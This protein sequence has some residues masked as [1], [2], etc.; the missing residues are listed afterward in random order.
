MAKQMT[1]PK[2]CDEALTRSAETFALDVQRAATNPDCH[3]WVSASAGTGKTK[4]LTDRILNLLLNGVNPRKILC[5]TF[6]NAAA[7]EMM[8]RLLDRLGHWASCSESALMRELRLL[9]RDGDTAFQEQETQKRARTLF[10]DIL[11]IPGGIRI[12]TIHSF[13]QSLLASFPLEAGLAL[14]TTILK[15]RER[16][17]ILK[18]SQEAVLKSSAHNPLL[19]E[20]MGLL[21]EQFHSET[22]KQLCDTLLEERLKLI[23]VLA[24]GLDAARKTTLEALD[25]DSIDL[26]RTVADKIGMI[27][28]ATLLDRLWNEESERLDALKKAALALLEGRSTDQKRGE[29]VF[30]WLEQPKTME[31]F[32]A[33]ASHFLTLEGEIRQKLATRDVLTSFP[34]VEDIL[35]KEAKRVQE[36]SD[37]LKRLKIA[38]ISLS[39]LTLGDALL[40]HYEALKT[41]QR[42]LDYD[43]LILKASALL[44]HSELAPW[45][46]Y[47]L[48]GGIDHLLVDEAQDTNTLQ[49]SIIKA[50]TEEFFAGEGVKA[51][52][53][54]LFAV[55]DGKQS[56]YS[57]QGTD[58]HIF[59][60]MRAYFARALPPD[61]K[62]KRWKDLE[63]SLSFRS[64]SAILDFIDALFA[65]EHVRDGVCEEDGLRHLCFRTGQAG[66]VELWPL[67]APEPTATDGHGQE[68]TQPSSA[69]PD[70]SANMAYT[71]TARTLLAQRVANQIERWLEK[72]TFLPSRGRPLK[73]DDIMVLVRNRTEFV[74]ALIQSL[75]AK[76]IPVSGLDRLDLLE[77]LAIQDLIALSEFLLLPENDFALA[78]V[79]KSPFGGLDE[80]ALFTLATTRNQKSLWENLKERRSSLQCFQDLFERLSSLLAQVDFVSPFTLYSEILFT[81]KGLQKIMARFGREAMDPIEE[82]LGLAYDYR[83][84]SSSSLQGFLHWLGQGPLKIKRDFS[85]TGSGQIRTM[86]VH[87]AKGLQAPVVILADTASRPVLRQDFLWSQEQEKKPALLWSPS[88]D[89]ETKTTRHLKRQLKILQDQ[90]YRRLLYVA[91]TR[92]EDQLYI[93]GAHENQRSI[94]GSWYH[95]IESAFLRDAVLSSRTEKISLPWGEGFRLERPQEVPSPPTDQFPDLPHLSHLPSPPPEEP[96][97][98]WLFAEVDAE[99]EAFAKTAVTKTG[100]DAQDVAPS[101]SPACLKG[102]LIHH[103]LEVLPLLPQEEHA[104]KILQSQQEWPYAKETFEEAVATVQDI[105]SD[106]NFAVLFQGNSKAEVPVVGHYQGKLYT[107]RLDR[108]VVFDDM[109]WILDYKTDATPP[110]RP[111]QIKRN[112]KNQLELY[113]ELMMSVY[114]R[115]QIKTMILWTETKQLM[116]V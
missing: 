8:Q 88:Q 92:A 81:H 94:E 83:G 3:V 49:W 13:C 50:L 58:P 72:G 76:G 30:L 41:E 7:S 101:S 1:L 26:D 59:T 51:Q 36:A 78:C 70:P 42:V 16:D 106:A 89:F 47:K 55:G 9:R 38:K 5:L 98:E 87:G 114:P 97:P 37:L 11:E 56:I 62:K 23:M 44:H 69:P 32:A 17:D 53:R 27:D 33:Y 61:E 63:M 19:E 91:L 57:F 15:D 102:R 65:N 28:P 54:T 112:Y 35:L 34:A 2:G 85:Q 6:T 77:E 21:A 14:E 95:L 60:A 40:T 90:E 110:S 43:D 103:L 39:L 12:Q 46:L 80:E 67:V 66:R 79:L 108:L 64:T 116:E 73:A 111:D 109:I 25:L 4:V 48:D 104:Q 45:I 31:A 71:V 24:S 68:A 115:H 75:K 100:S 107:G 20:A 52:A 84:Q 113:R 96:T 82:F 10:I 99:E 18:Q 29:A 22:F 105:L 86:T 93:C 74:P